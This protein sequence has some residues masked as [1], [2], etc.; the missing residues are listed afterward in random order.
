MNLQARLSQPMASASLTVRPGGSYPEAGRN[1]D[2]TTRLRDIGSTRFTHSESG[3]YF[4]GIG[5]LESPENESVG[6][7]QTRPESGRISGMK[8]TQASPQIY[9]QNLLTKRILKSL[10]KPL[11]F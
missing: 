10:P 7:S 2:Q 4:E 5:G 3:V 1:A 6:H 9:R 11:I 8:V